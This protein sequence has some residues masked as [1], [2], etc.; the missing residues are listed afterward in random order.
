MAD[1]A[2]ATDARRDG[3]HFKEH[4]SLAESLETTKLIDVK[5]SVFDLVCIVQVDRHAGVPLDAG[6][7]FDSYLLTHDYSPSNE[8]SLNVP[9]AQPGA[10]ARG[11]VTTRTLGFHP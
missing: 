1:R 7:G 4:S 3:R 5:V 8:S 10:F 6:Y 11:I 2:N 9:V